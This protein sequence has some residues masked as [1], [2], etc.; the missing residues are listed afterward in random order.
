MGG[1]GGSG[2]VDRAR[3]LPE[4]LLH[5]QVNGEW[6]FVQTQRHLVLA[7]DCWLRRMVK[8]IARPYHPW[9]LGGS[10]LTS[11][12]RWGIDPDAD[13]SLEQVLDLRRA[14]MDEVRDVIADATAEELERNGVP[15]DSPGH[16]RK[17]HTVLQCLHVILKEEWQHRRYAVRTLRCLR[18]GPADSSP[19]CARTSDAEVLAVPHVSGMARDAQCQSPVG[20]LPRCW[21]R[22]PGDGLCHGHGRRQRGTSRRHTAGGW[23]P[24]GSKGKRG[25][26]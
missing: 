11:P 9:G 22:S 7:T 4:P 1:S 18:I 13:P 20:D 24:I 10:W 5:E 3:K 21:S 14:R 15:P 8:G 23:L 16:P 6:S 17:D 26:G 12:H 19:R 25:L 2:T